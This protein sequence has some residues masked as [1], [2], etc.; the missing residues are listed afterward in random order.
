MNQSVI[1]T[2][3]IATAKLKELVE[4]KEAGAKP[5]EDMADDELGAF[6]KAK[7]VGREQG[8]L[9]KLALVA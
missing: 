3:N 6:L 7:G 2:G 8:A 9:I 1:E 5:S 4:A